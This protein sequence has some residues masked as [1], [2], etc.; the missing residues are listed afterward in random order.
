MSDFHKIRS[1]SD[2]VVINDHYFTAGALDKNMPNGM[3]EVP[4]NYPKIL[5]KVENGK[6]YVLIHKIGTP[7]SSS[8]Y[9][10]KMMGEMMFKEVDKHTYKQ[11][12]EY[13][14]SGRELYLKNVERSVVNQ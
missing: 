12:Q 7:V 14:Q 6:Y 13:L 10:D 5:C 9:G 2:T 4:E 3:I 1:V 8:T 11:Y